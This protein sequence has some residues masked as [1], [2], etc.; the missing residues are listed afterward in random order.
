MASGIGEDGM[1]VASP[2]PV[3]SSVM[4]TMVRAYGEALMNYQASETLFDEHYAQIRFSD[5]TWEILNA[6]LDAS[7]WQDVPIHEFEH[8]FDEC[9]VC[10]DIMKAFHGFV[11][12]RERGEE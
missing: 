11:Q 10:Y 2:W 1:R 9:E 8:P 4:V 5:G 12:I 3:F 7:S 6:M